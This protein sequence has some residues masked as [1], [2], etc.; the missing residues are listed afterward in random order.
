MQRVYT[1]VVGL[2]ESGNGRSCRDHV[3]C[4]TVV[5]IGSILLLKNTTVV[6]QDGKNEFAI[7]AVLLTD[8]VESCTVGFIGREFHFRRF[9]YSDKLIEVAELLSESANSEHRRRSHVHRGIAICI[10]IS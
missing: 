9:D 10:R 5:N 7:K 3:A 4:G 2:L 1:E 8:G 6:N